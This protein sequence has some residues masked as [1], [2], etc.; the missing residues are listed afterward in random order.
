MSSI[1][2]IIKWPGGKSAELPFIRPVLG[3]VPGRYFEP[4]LGGGAV[5]L[6]LPADRQAY[7]SDA[8][9]SLVGVYEGL[10]T[11]DH[12]FM[13]CVLSLGQTRCR[14]CEL[15]G[16]EEWRRDY[17]GVPALL[18]GLHDPEL[19]ALV[20]P[21]ILKAS[22][23]KERWMARM[24]V[25]PVASIFETAIQAGFYNAVRQQMNDLPE[26]PQ[27]SACFWFVREYAYGG[28]FKTTKVGRECVAY[29]GASYNRRQFTDRI[30]QAMAPDMQARLSATTFQA[31]DFEDLLTE[32]A[33]GAGDT[34]FLDPPYDRGFST[35]DR[36]A[37]TADDHRRLADWI[38]RTK[39]R[40]VLVVASTEQS[41]AIYGNIP[42]S[43]VMRFGLRYRQ[44]IKGRFNQQATH[45]MVVRPGEGMGPVAGMTAGELPDT[46][47]KT[48][49]TKP[50]S[51][52]AAEPLMEEMR[53]VA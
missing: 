16:L 4:F 51:V 21:A 42:G 26:G 12:D 23:I 28:M 6:G 35:Y 48:T 25:E 20:L 27:Q 3:D 9:V 37:F 31:C 40:C 18:D 32:Y 53:H 15:D 44:G 43:E 38:G 34:V 41:E 49:T 45:L 8:S 30:T 36:N 13:S 29:G 50:A 47:K 19:S 2:P 46:D 33:A 7:A 10:K 17:A 1:R 52:P 14:L 24:G 11:Q 5:L 22:G 39:S